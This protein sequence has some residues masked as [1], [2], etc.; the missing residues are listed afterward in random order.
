MQA[1]SVFKLRK[2][3]PYMPSQVN[4]GKCT[5]E[6]LNVGA[7]DSVGKRTRMEDK[8]NVLQ[9]SHED[10]KRFKLEEEREESPELSEKDLQISFFVVCDGHGGHQ[11]ADY[12]NQNLFENIISSST[13]K[14]DTLLAIEEGFLTTET[15]LLLKSKKGELDGGIGSTVAAVLIVNKSLYVANIGDTEVVLATKGN[16]MVLTELHTLENSE[17][18]GRVEK[19]GGRIIGK[20]EFRLG[21]P[22][23]NPSYV[24]IGVTRSFGDFYFK[25]EQWTEKR[26]SGLIAEPKIIEWN[27]TLDDEFLIIASDGFWDVVKKEEAVKF[28]RKV[29][30]LETSV[31]CK[32]LINLGQSRKSEDNLTVLIIKLAFSS[33]KIQ[34]TIC[35]SNVK[36]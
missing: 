16:F 34:T 2:S 28:V 15:D 3:K 6:R 4:L 31:I 26:N 27:L 10:L 32:L 11:V 35:R 29:I 33:Q 18:K 14:K 13:F 23:W 12:V 5:L 30:N 1:N 7:S 17:E 24:N 19:L 20:S 36:R 8:H 21:H 9:I 22:L 25:E